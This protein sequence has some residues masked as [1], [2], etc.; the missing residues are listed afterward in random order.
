MTPSLLKEAFLDHV[1]LEGRD[2]IYKVIDLG[3]G[4]GLVGVEFK[5]ISGTLTGIDLSKKMVRKAEEKDIYDELYVDDIIDRLEALDS[6]FDLFISADVLVYI[7]NLCPLFR[8]VKRHSRENSL[9]IFSTEH[10]DTGDFI[11]QKTGRYAHSKDY[12]LSV[13]T[14]SGLQLDYF[15]KSNLRREKT[16]WIIGGIYILRCV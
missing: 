11:L 3:C 12:I 8:C 14:E 2:R 16:N 1:P 5:D 7:G 13:A 15:I 9:F 10:T 6:K 4:T